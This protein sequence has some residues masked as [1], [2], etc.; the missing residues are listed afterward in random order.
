MKIA[1]RVAFL[2]VAAFLTPPAWPQ[3]QSV[4]PQGRVQAIDSGTGAIA[5]VVLDADTGQPLPNA[6]VVLRK[7]T[8]L[9][10]GS[11]SIASYQR[12]NAAEVPSYK[13]SLDPT[14]HFEIQGVPPGEYLLWVGGDGYVAH[15]YKQESNGLTGGKL[16]LQADTKLTLV[17]PILLVAAGVIAGR[18]TDKQRRP[19]PWTLVQAIQPI[20][21]AL[22]I[23]NEMRPFAQIWTNDRGEYR[24]F[25]LPPGRYYVAAR[26][27]PG[28][29]GATPVQQ[30]FPAPGF[31]RNDF[32]SVQYFY[33]GT[34]DPAAAGA[35]EVLGGK[36]ALGINFWPRLPLMK[37]AGLR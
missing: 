10:P 30:E 9:Q 11:A 19:L 14:G 32:D 23:G 25:G 5:G 28:E 12:P 26:F 8:G 36:E 29:S 21:Q 18:V 15:Y 33:P 24:F 2:V 37:S 3:D 7:W 17:S 34:T 27:Q 4:Q 6:W 31:G 1:A 22:I 16:I 35:I 13:T 20:S